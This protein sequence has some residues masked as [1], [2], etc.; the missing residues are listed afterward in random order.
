MKKTILLLSLTVLHTLVYSAN[1]TV[2]N[3]DDNGTG[4]LRQ[5]IADASGG[6]TITFNSS[7]ISSGN[8]VLPLTSGQLVVDKALTIIG[9]MTSS[10]TL[11]ISGGDSY[12]I[13]SISGGVSNL[14]DLAL[15]DAY[16]ASKDRGGA[17]AFGSGTPTAT[18]TNCF[19]RNNSAPYGGGI[20]AIGTDL[21]I[22][23]STIKG[24]SATINGG[25]IACFS[26][27][28]E[29]SPMTRLNI[30][31]SI[32]KENSA[33]SGGGMTAD[34]FVELNECEISN[35]TASANG[36]GIYG[37][38]IGANFDIVNSTFT[39]NNA[40][41]RGGA[42]YGQFYVIGVTNSTFHMNSST[43]SSNASKGGAIYV[44]NCTL[45]ISTSTFNQN[46]SFAGGA[47]NS[48]NG[49]KL[50]VKNSTISGNTAT[51][52]GGIYSNV[53]TAA[54]GSNIV[55]LNTG[56]DI[57]HPNVS[58]EGFN[59]FGF[60]P[61]W[62]QSTDQ[63]DVDATALKL[64]SLQDNGG[65]TETMLPESGSVAIDKGDSTDTSDAQNGSIVGRRDVGSAE[66]GIKTTS[67]KETISTYRLRIYPNPTTGL[68]HIKNE[69]PIDQV[70]VL[71]ITGKALID[72]RTQNS[73]LD[74]S[75][76]PT[77]VYILK[78]IENGSLATA[79]FI[80]Q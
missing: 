57:N 20:Y 16:V 58:N 1:I 7:L 79:R 19:I 8:A 54:L 44:T 18:I 80:K 66:T 29:G 72:T 23:N 60:S 61:S 34:G 35:N 69:Q 2:T 75:Q 31:N 40:T 27:G 24:N 42:L 55:A 62:A 17:I 46:E 63:L 38:S 15:V 76:L 48:D 78:V 25:G 59:I 10:D 36:A 14:K 49:S 3:L 51:V 68:L 53:S 77:G 52:Y 65:K 70:T 4:S 26:S 9:L 45:N 21:T 50:S 71:D 37:N 74:V 30:S 73:T 64:G 13:F 11:F 6:D 41:E 47:I 22:T 33:Q 43:P 5:A 56:G 28:D 39:G 67:I 32:I 12:R